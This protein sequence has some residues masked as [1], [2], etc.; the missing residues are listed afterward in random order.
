MSTSSSEKA[1]HREL[2]NR[3][4]NKVRS[5][6]HAGVPLARFSAEERFA[7]DS[8]TVHT[9]YGLAEEI[10]TTVLLDQILVSLVANSVRAE[11][12]AGDVLL[13][14]PL[15]LSA[16]RNTLAKQYG[17][18]YQKFLIKKILVHFSTLSPAT[19]SG[20][21]A[22]GIIDDPNLALY[23]KGFPRLQQLMTTA[24]TDIKPI[25]ED[26][27]I[28]F[29]PEEC[30]PKYITYDELGRWESFGTLYALAA[31]DFQ[32]VDTEADVRTVGY[33]YLSSVIELYDP[34]LRQPLDESP[35][36]LDSTGAISFGTIFS[37]GPTTAQDEPVIMTDTHAPL[38][39]DE[40]GIL[41]IFNDWTDGSIPYQW[42]D[43][44][45]TINPQRGD[46]F[47][48]RK[49]FSGSNRPLNAVFRTFGASS[50]DQAL[51]WEGSYG[52]N[53]ADLKYLIK[54]YKTL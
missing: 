13:K 30:E 25:W 5:S 23:T 4:Y 15:V 54:F 1:G 34:I 46:T 8:R 32:K 47:F 42:T 39:D 20:G 24:E 6:I 38:A 48:I 45:G 19:R 17:T 12:Q 31:G 22:I 9:K 26:A 18:M 21:I 3:Q 10:V 27:T 28:E 35:D 52:V 14:I 36:V 41:Y 37:Y 2:T 53:T 44:H 51:F 33:M 11:T 7:T 40:Y 29:T 50:I 49:S 16:F 43:S